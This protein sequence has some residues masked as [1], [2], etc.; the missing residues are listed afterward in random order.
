MA[1]FDFA[2]AGTDV[3]S[4]LLAGLLARDHGKKIVRIG[5][6][7]SPQRLWRQV[8]LSLPLTASPVRWS[9]A[10]QASAETLSLVGAIGARDALRPVECGVVSDT[11]AS[12]GALDHIAHLAAGSGHQLRRLKHGWAFRRVALID[13]DAIDA[14]LAEWLRTLNVATLEGTEADAA[15]TILADDAAILDRLPETARPEILHSPAMTST[16]LATRQTGEA[17]Q[18]FLD[19]GVTLLARPGGTSLALVSGEASVDARLAS[20]LHGPF[21]VKRLA[22]THYR[23]LVMRDGAPLIG[24]PKGSK[25]IIIAGLGANAAFMAPAIARFL[26]GSASAE[27]KACLG[28]HDPSRPR[29][30]LIDFMPSVELLP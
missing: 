20:T 6:V 14:K 25:A 22:T 10:E 8:P 7:P 15:A 26:A 4:A 30:S 1:E 27:E 16:L 9:I 3:F 5:P 23:R 11:V 29:D 2:I 24:R 28:A 19:R 18:I 13:R 17:V 12:A 21:P